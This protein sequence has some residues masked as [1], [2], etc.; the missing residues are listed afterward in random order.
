MA[1]RIFRSGRGHARTVSHLPVLAPLLPGT[2]VFIGQTGLTQASSADGGRL[3]LLGDRD[4][5]GFEADAFNAQEPL[6]QPYKTGETGVAYIIEP[7]Q[8]YLWAMTAGS[9]TT[10]QP[11]TVGPAGRLMAAGSARIVAYF[12]SPSRTCGAGELIDVTIA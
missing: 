7:A 1:N 10:G 2:G 5:Q 4:Y 6:L 12:D 8:E 11:L 3:A 9:Y